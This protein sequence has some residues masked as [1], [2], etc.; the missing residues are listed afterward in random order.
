MGVLAYVE[1]SG[2]PVLLCILANREPDVP[3]QSARRGDLSLAWWSRNGRNNLVS[4]H[5][6]EERAVAPAQ[7][8]EKQV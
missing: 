5:I 7:M 3:T 1:P 4:G 6:P 2:A 8:I